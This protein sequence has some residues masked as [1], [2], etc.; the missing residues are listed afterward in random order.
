MVSVIN[1]YLEEIRVVGF[2]AKGG[3]TTLFDQSALLGVP[4]R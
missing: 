2:A 4:G 3:C 1:N